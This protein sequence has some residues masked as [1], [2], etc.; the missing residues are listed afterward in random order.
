VEVE[1]LVGAWVKLTSR[2]YSFLLPPF[3][4]LAHVQ[5]Y[6]HLGSS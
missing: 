5:R 2:L 6:E 4:R 3:F 1:V